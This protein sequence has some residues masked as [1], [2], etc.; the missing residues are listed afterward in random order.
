MAT[1]SPEAVVIRA[2][3]IPA[4]TAAGS[5]APAWAIASKP[6]EDFIFFDAFKTKSGIKKK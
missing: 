6:A 5:P 1:I 2:C 4:A 3:E